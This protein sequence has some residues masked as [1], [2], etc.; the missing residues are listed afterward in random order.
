MQQQQQQ[1]LIVR[2][3]ELESIL[4]DFYNEAIDLLQ[5]PS[6]PNQSPL[7]YN[8]L[9]TF[10]LIF[11]CNLL[12]NNCD[13]TSSNFNLNE[14]YNGKQIRHILSQ[15]R[16]IEKKFDRFADR[17]KIVYFLLIMYMSYGP[18]GQQSDLYTFYFSEETNEIQRTLLD[19]LNSEL[20]DFKNNNVDSMRM[21]LLLKL[22]QF[23]WSLGQFGV[24]YNLYF[25][26]VLS[27]WD[28]GLVVYISFNLF[29]LIDIYFLFIFIY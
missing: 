23:I 2:R 6:T 10:C 13:N 20:I 9:V 1:P 14:G 21:W 12:N 22:D 5:H 19:L 7:P 16:E 15:V 27:I 11:G 24:K 3:S 17:I 4:I 25:V 29:L 8:L 28:L 26:V 18:S